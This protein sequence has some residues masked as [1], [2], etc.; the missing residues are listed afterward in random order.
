MGYLGLFGIVF[1]FKHTPCGAI[2]SILQEG[3]WGKTLG[4]PGIK[5]PLGVF[6]VLTRNGGNGTTEA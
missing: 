2:C 3:G 6:E 5:S 4:G 1:F